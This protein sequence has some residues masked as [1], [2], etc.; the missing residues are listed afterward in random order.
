MP[1]AYWS[2]WPVSFFAFVLYGERDGK[3]A[4]AN[5][6]RDSAYTSESVQ[7]TRVCMSA[8]VVVQPS[9][10]AAQMRGYAAA[11]RRIGPMKDRGTAPGKRW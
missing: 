10:L 6:D 5:K 2:L 3:M 4:V 7:R 9:T 8:D 1:L 11:E